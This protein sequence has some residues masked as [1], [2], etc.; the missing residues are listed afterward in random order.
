[1]PGFAGGNHWE[2]V[3]FEA[4]A[5]GEGEITLAQRR[6][7]ESTAEPDASTFKFMLKAS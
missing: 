4:V 3:V 6:P 1:L 7:W 2:V 5:A